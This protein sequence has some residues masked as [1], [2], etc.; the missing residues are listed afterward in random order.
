MP[1]IHGPITFEVPNL[2]CMLD[3]EDLHAMAHVLAALSNYASWKSKA[4]TS[5]ADGLINTALYCERQCNRIYE[6]LPTWARW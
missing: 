6:E 4:M 3:P 2:D 5:R 1:T